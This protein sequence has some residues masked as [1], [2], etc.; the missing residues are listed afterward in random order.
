M[1]SGSVARSRVDG[2]WRLGWNVD[3]LYMVKMVPMARWRHVQSDQCATC[4]V[5]KGS[6]ERNVAAQTSNATLSI[7]LIPS[8]PPHLK[9]TPYLLIPTL[10]PRPQ[11]RSHPTRSPTNATP[12]PS[13]P[14]TPTLLLSPSPPSSHNSDHEVRGEEGRES[15]LVREGL[16]NE[17]GGGGW[18]SEGRVVEQWIMVW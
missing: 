3:V 12:S 6:R 7:T 2:A 15:S 18:R 4:N 13:P 14:L 9:K 17:G 5:R 1:V 8:H 10:R 11:S 16:G